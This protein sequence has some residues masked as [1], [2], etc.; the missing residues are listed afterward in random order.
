[1]TVI[2]YQVVT[3]SVYVASVELQYKSLFFIARRSE[4]LL[5]W[6]A[7]GALNNHLHIE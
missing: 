5:L 1:M 2:M 4:W 3:V 6:L 7:L